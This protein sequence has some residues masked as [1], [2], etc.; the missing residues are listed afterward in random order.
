MN[1]SC[2]PIDN[3]TV[4]RIFCTMIVTRGID[5]R[6]YPNKGQA[7]FINKMVGATRIVYN[8]ILYKKQKHWDEYKENLKIKPTDLYSEY[9]W[10]KGL[11][12]QGICNAYND[13]M[14][15]YNNWFSNLGKKNNSKAKSPKYK[16]KSKSGSYRNAMCQKKCF[17]TI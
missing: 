14:K 6:L 4:N 13:L 9:E 5:I 15:A 12:S 7:N 2:Y 17:K 1:N 11:D 3:A 10:L 16:K 8:T